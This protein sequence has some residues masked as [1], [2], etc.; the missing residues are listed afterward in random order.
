M[1]P[2]WIAV[3]TLCLI[4][5]ISEIIFLAI[6]KLKPLFFVIVNSLKTGV[7]TAAFVTSML[8]VSK[9]DPKLSKG[10]T[11]GGNVIVLLV[12]LLI[13]L[14][15]YADFYTELLSGYHS[16]TA[17]SSSSRTAKEREL[18]LLSMGH[19]SHRKLHISHA[20]TIPLQ[21]EWLRQWSSQFIQ[22]RG[23]PAIIIPAI[24]GSKHSARS[25]AVCLTRPVPFLGTRGITTR[26]FH[27]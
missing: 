15:G 24:Q 9:D 1:L 12:I 23:A 20:P 6:H 7:W 18:I 16:S 14:P 11:V 26:M 3:S 2:V 19:S 21:R 4:I 25:V 17:S 5:T 8:S 22:G 13:F 27:K 10:V